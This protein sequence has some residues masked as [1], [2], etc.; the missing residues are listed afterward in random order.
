MVLALDFFH[1]FLYL[2]F[3]L[4][5]NHYLGRWKEHLFNILFFT[6]FKKFIL[7][8][9][10]ELPIRTTF[11]LKFSCSTGDEWNLVYNKT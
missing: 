2:C 5:T 4:A 11:D 7:K 9:L 8:Y 3:F 1:F 10:V 6:H